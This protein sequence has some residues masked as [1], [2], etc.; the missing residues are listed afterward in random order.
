MADTTYASTSA[1]R[2]YVRRVRVTFAYGMRLTCEMDLSVSDLEGL[3][4]SGDVEANA[5]CP[6]CGG[7]VAE[8]PEIAPL[9][10]DWPQRMYSTT[11]GGEVTATELDIVA[12]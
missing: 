2:T 11:W 12:S 7:H 3:R 6:D 9:L 10:L 4:R 1:A 8:C 5:F